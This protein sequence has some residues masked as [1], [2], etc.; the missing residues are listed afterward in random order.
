[1]KNRLFFTLTFFCMIISNAQ[2]KEKIE[3][4]KW[5]AAAIVLDNS[6]VKEL[7]KDWD[8]LIKENG[9]IGYGLQVYDEENNNFKLV[10][11]QHYPDRDYNANW[12]TVNVNTKEAF[13][14]NMADPL[15]NKKLKISEKDWMKFKSCK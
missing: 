12:F 11:V 13:E 9:G 1:M 7:T 10:L 2:T 8:K 3:E 4:C 6:Y 14:E 15:Y 5:V